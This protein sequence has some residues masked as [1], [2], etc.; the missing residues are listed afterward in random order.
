[1]F[2]KTL[3]RKTH[4][5]L[6]ASQVYPEGKPK[7]VDNTVPKSLNTYEVIRDKVMHD[8]KPKAAPRESLG[9]NPKPKGV[10]KKKLLS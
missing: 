1:M 7:K 3:P 10:G 5:P 2:Q 9:T 6:F 8:M 4:T